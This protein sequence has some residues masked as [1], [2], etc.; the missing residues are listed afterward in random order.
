MQ[1]LLGWRRNLEDLLYQQSGL[2]LLQTT[3]FVIGVIFGA[4]ALR[5]V[6]DATRLDLVRQLSH[7]IE[8]FLIGQGPPGGVLLREALIMYGKYMAIFWILAISLVGVVGVMLLTLV[9]GFA[10]GF[11]VAFLSAEMGLRGLLVAAAAHLPQ[12]L[13]EVPALILG[14]SASVAFALEVVRS[15][16]AHRRM[17]G[18]YEALAGYTG[19]LLSVGVLLLGAG[20]VNGYLTPALVRWVSSLLS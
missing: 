1:L 12:S 8:L 17:A 5:S 2:V 10:S 16:R 9:R 3:L 7:S 4:L 20:L 19:T 13:L 6:E 11:V 14:G 18:F 15:W